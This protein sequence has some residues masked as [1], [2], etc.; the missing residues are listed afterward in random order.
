[1][2]GG[3]QA[4]TRTPNVFE[5]I[6][7]NFALVGEDEHPDGHYVL[8]PA[9]EPPPVRI[10][11]LKFSKP[12]ESLDS[13]VVKLTAPTTCGIVRLDMQLNYTRRSRIFR[14][15]GIDVY[16]TNAD[17]QVWQGSISP[18]ELNQ[19]FITYISPLPPTAFHKVFGRGPIQGVAWDKL[20]YRSTPTDLLGAKAS[21]VQI[22]AINC[23]DPD[24]F[25]PIAESTR[26]K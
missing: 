19:R 17:Q 6:Y 15:S 16:L 14:T 26:T 13:G 4:I 12:R 8:R 11:P 18:L 3:V 5:Y 21:H 2:T 10:E 22:F 24:K 20:E 23:L 7:K 25:A 1:L 9:D